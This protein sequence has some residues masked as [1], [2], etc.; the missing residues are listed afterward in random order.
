MTASSPL[1]DIQNLTHQFGANGIGAN[2]NSLTIL[3]DISFAVNP[4]EFVCVLGPSGCGKSTLLSLLAGF[5]TPTQGRILMNGQPIRQPGADR[6]VIFQEDALFPWLTVEE[7]IAF[8]LWAGGMD[9]AAAMKAVDRF[10]DLVGLAE[11]RTYLPREISGGMKQRV[12]LARVL[13]LKPQ[14]L[15]MDEPFGALDAQTRENM[16]DLLLSLWQQFHHTIV[17]VTHDVR[18]ALLLA[19]RILLLGGK[20]GSLKQQIPMTLDRPR[21]T[22]SSDFIKCYK[23]LHDDLQG[24]RVRS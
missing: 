20:P 18:E 2:G 9:K 5:L 13:V 8:G 3:A 16:Q 12:A 19:D 22:E 21:R 24:S 6:C 1:L 23:D 11:F 10:L 15:L 17:F 4:G 14:V 7:N